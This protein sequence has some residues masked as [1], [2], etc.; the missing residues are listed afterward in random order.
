PCW[1]VG[2]PD[3]WDRAERAT[4]RVVEITELQRQVASEL[5]CGFVSARDI[6]GGDGGFL[7][8][9]QASPPLASADGVHLSKEGYEKLGAELARLLLPPVPGGTTAREHCAA[10][11]S[12]RWCSR[13]PVR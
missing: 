10:P 7:A 8:W 5:G 11:W 3:A 1:I 12:H 9:R 13:S 2:P 6:M 4:V